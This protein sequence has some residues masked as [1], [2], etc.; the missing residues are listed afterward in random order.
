MKVQKHSSVNTGIQKI[1][2][3]NLQKCLRVKHK[4]VQIV[5]TKSN[6]WVKITKN[7][8]TVFIP[9]SSNIQYW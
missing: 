7:E 1:Y 4:P 2:R 3:R 8:V 9:N 5:D 6:I